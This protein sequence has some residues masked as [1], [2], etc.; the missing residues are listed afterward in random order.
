[1]AKVTQIKEISFTPWRDALLPASF[2]GNL[3]HVES[4][5]RQSGRRIVVHEFP[6]K[7]LPYSEDMGRAAVEWQVRGYTITY[8][9]NTLEPLYSRDY[10]AARDLLQQR[11]DE[12][13]PGRLQLPTMLPMLVVCQRY[14]LTEEE[15][16]GGYCVFDMSFVEYGAPPFRPKPKT[17]QQLY[18][19]SVAVRERVMTNLGR[20]QAF[21]PAG[22]VP[23]AQLRPGKPPG[24]RSTIPPLRQFAPGKPPGA[25]STV[26]PTPQFVPGGPSGGS[27]LSELPAGEP[28]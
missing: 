16:F 3:F 25:P 8:P 27:G 7:D 17:D 1:M 5:S 19:E 13:G 24:A 21:Q 9:Q 20:S 6:K 23:V 22:R 15:R 28:Q 26:P 14:R 18:A 2:D 11:L 12:G 10:R 4:G